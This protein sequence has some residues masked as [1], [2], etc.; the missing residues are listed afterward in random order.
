MDADHAGQPAA[1]ILALTAVATAIVALFQAA[2]ELFAQLPSRHGIDGGVNGFVGQ[3]KGGVIRM[4]CPQPT[5]DLLRGPALAQ[6]FND[7]VGC[8]AVRLKFARLAREAR[9]LPS[10][11]PGSSDI[12][13]MGLQTLRHF[14][15]YGAGRPL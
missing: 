6:Q 14:P 2:D 1:S 7:N 10:L 15:A 11:A 12:V 3:V 5:L 4:V 9:A 8:G 13:A